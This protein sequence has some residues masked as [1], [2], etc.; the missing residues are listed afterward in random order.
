MK[1]LIGFHRHAV[2]CIIGVNPSER[3][4]EQVLYMS[5]KVRTSFSSCVQTDA[6]EDTINYVAL[7]QKCTEIAKEKKYHLLEALA[8]HLLQRILDE[9]PI[10][11]AWIAIQKPS[12]LPSAEYTFVEIEGQKR[13]DGRLDIGNGWR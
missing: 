13:D 9:F 3:T 7:A 6:I 1:G 5:L 8:Y 2:S 11:W 4:V 10:E 12:A